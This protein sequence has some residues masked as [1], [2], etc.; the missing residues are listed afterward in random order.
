MAERTPRITV[1]LVKDRD[2]PNYRLQWIVPGTTQRRSK[3]AR[4]DD[5]DE[6]ERARQDL[7]YELNHGLFVTP[8]ARLSWEDF[9]A[10]YL[11]EKLADRRGNTQRKWRAVCRS[12]VRLVRPRELCAVDASLLS[13]YQAALRAEGRSKATIAGHLAYLRASLRWAARLGLVGQAPTVEMPKLP[14]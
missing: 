13:R 11:A 6:A 14:R 9:S 1:W 2:R 4:T 5:P 12:F 7:E 8:P 10:R 3:S